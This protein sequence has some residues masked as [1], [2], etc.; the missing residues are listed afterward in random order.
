MFNQKIFIIAYVCFSVC[1]EFCILMFP[2]YATKK[3]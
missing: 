3:A 1:K 2:T